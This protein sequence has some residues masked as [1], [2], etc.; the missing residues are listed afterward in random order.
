MYVFF[1]HTQEI[2]TKEEYLRLNSGSGKSLLETNNNYEKKS[3]L[4]INDI[5]TNNSDI[6]N[7]YDD[8]NNGR[9][10]NIYNEN[11]K[12]IKGNKLISKFE[13][14]AGFVPGKNIQP[15]REVCIDMFIFLSIMHLNCEYLFIDLFVYIF[16]YLRVR[17]LTFLHI[18]INKRCGCLYLFMYELL[19][20]YTSKTE[21]M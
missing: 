9:I 15:A 20:I 8:K 3:D 6:D 4:V 1:T 21:Y 16:I 11:D 12:N 18:P 17:I 13:N 2:E 5:N 7:N 10:K 19:F 14:S